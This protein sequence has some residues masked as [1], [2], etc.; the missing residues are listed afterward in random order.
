IL[1]GLEVGIVLAIIGAIVGEYLGGNTGLGALLIA[2]M[3]AYETDQMFAV[4]IHM[5]LLGFA[6]YF[7][8][9]ALRRVLIPWHQSAS[10]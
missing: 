8:I 6:F 1:T 9:G 3:N 7:A 2:R 5:S 4:L 10:H